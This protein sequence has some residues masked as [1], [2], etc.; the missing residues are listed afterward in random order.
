[1]IDFIYSFISAAIVLAGIYCYDEHIRKKQWLQEK[2]AW[3]SLLVNAQAEIE[4]LSGGDTE[5]TREIERY[6]DK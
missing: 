4:R 2:N 6:L 5:L 1:M 3:R